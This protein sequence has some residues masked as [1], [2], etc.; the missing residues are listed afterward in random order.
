MLIRHEHPGDEAQ[1]FQVNRLAFETP[2]E[3]GI[4]DCLRQNC[5]EGLS[6]VAEIDG[7]IVGHILFTPAVI[8]SGSIQVAG[9]GLAPMAVL[10][11]YQGK[12]IGSA[13]VRT[14]LEEMRITFTSFVVVLGHPGFYPKFGFQKASQYGIHS[15][16]AEIP[17]E[18]FMI[19]VFDQE[20]L[21]GVHGVAHQ[22]PEFLTAM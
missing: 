11:E 7:K 13:L 21:N 18:A 8:I 20:K 3:A 22:R 19:V 5:P 16:Y 10:P 15:E 1:I 4:V 12:G 17:D 9:M 2:V 6:L 14:G